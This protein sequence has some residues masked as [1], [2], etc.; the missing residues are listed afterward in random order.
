MKTNN[1]TLLALLASDKDLP[2][3]DLFTITLASGYQLFTTNSDVPVYANGQYFA[4]SGVRID[5]LK[6]RQETSIKADEQSITIGALP[7]DT[8]GGLP[9]LE[10]LALGLWDLA[11]IQRDRAFFDPTTLPNPVP[12]SGLVPVGTVTLN[13]GYVAA[14]DK[15]GRTTADIK[16]QTMTGLL[17]QQMPRRVFQLTCLHVWGTSRLVGGVETM[18]GINPMD[19]VETALCGTGT[20]QS[21]ISWS[22]A[23]VAANWYQFGTLTFTG[24][25]NTGVERTVRSS[26]YSGGVSTAVLVIPF[27]EPV[28]VGDSF[29]VFAGDDHSL[30][31]CTNKFNNAANFNGFPFVPPASTAY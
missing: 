1:A 24:G 19:Y 4:A 25:A 15:V 12:L 3:I 10:S 13:Y 27:D 8:I 6:F 2:I 26:T 30:P 21:V 23:N 22:G 31:T 9:V 29:N 14:L 11:T 17:N 20:T 28:T 18:C 5:G 7:T 16:F